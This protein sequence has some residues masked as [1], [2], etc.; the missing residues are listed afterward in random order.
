M[1]TQ[2]LEV[3][4]TEIVTADGLVATITLSLPEG[5]D[6]A[7]SID[8]FDPLPV[9]PRGNTYILLITDRVSHRADIYA[10]TAVEF[11]A[12]GP[13][14]ILI[15]RSIPLWGC[16]RGIHNGLQFC[17]KFSHAVDRRLGVRQIATSSYRHNGNGSVERIRHT[18]S[19][20]L[21]IVVDELQQ[22]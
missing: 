10:V 8:Y 2:L 20:M 18:I 5:P 9:K 6:N 3:P 11:T 21:A 7:V 13:A 19:Q 1:I 22:N 4:G 17:Y 15:N 16:P 12:V 14:K